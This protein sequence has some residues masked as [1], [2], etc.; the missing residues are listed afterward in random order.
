[1]GEVPPGNNLLDGR[2]R[3]TS[4]SIH[5]DVRA[6]R[7]CC[8]AEG[9]KRTTLSLHATTRSGAV[10]DAAH[11]GCI[12]PV[13]AAA[14]C[15][16]TGTY[17]YR[18]ANLKLLS[19]SYM[20]SQVSDLVGRAQPGLLDGTDLAAWLDFLVAGLGMSPDAFFRLIRHS[21]QALL[22]N[23]PYVAGHAVLLLRSLGFSEQQVLDRILPVYPRLL[24]LTREQR[25]AALAALALLDP[26]EG[27]PEAAVE[28]IRQC[29]SFLL[30]DVYGPL[31]PILDRIRASR[32][33][34]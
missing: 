30:P 16:D 15:S 3:M 2:G 7:H 11:V 25:D 29:P 14:T 20:P 8:Y 26:A 10:A 6:H 28:M 4:R 23:T 22:G 21:P 13:N 31:A 17:D 33:G 19:A 9:A 1:M 32:V 18:E 24:S 12:A 34:K 5:T 27:P